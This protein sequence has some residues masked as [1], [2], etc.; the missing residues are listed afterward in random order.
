[1]SKKLKN[2]KK[3]GFKTPKD[4]FDGLEDAVFSQLST[5]NLQESIDNHGFSMPEGYM[6][7]IEDKVFNKLDQDA[8]KV[9]SLFSRRNILYVSGVAAAIVLMF[10]IFMNRDTQTIEDLD[11]NLVE[12]YILDQ[13][14]SSY[15]LASLL[16]EE[17]LTSINDDIMQEV[18]DEESL[19]DYLLENVNLEDIIE[20]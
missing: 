9:V 6:N 15:E 19:E 10:S 11:Q 20:Q 1:M 14:I 17:E 12:N 4:Y 2:I 16:T 8:T 13:D 18:Y 3:P 5:K 7:G